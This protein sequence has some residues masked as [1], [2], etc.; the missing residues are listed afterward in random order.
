VRVR[1]VPHLVATQQHIVAGCRKGAC[2]RGGAACSSVRTVA[3]DAGSRLVV[4][5]ADVGSRPPEVA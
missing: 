1:A 3:L 5:P 4:Q 2:R